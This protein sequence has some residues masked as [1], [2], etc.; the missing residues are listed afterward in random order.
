MVSWG[1]VPLLDQNGNI[2]SYTVTYTSSRTGSKETSNVNASANQTTLAGL[3]EHTGYR[4]TVFASTA[5]GGGVE[6]TPIEVITEEDSKFKNAVF[7][8]QILLRLSGRL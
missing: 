1:Q 4:I 3:N 2:V 6:S 5:K 7:F 8:L